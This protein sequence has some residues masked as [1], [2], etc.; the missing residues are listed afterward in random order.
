M[1]ES[2]FKELFAPTVVLVCICL[3][4]SLLLAGTYL[5][6]KP[7][8]EIITKKNAD[9]A[10]AALVPSA[11][12]FKDM[13]GA[14]EF[15][16][17]VDEVFATEDNSAYVITSHSKGFGGTVTV[18]TALDS[19]GKVI[20]VKVTDAS[21]ETPGLGSKATLSSHTDKFKGSAKITDAEGGDGTYIQAVT[22]ASYTS[23]AVYRSV[24]AALQQFKLLGGEK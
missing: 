1:K 4:A 17:G 19:E 12:G 22:G 18:M 24:D 6:T 14:V 15:A 5:V 11:T 7:Q 2:K 13:A 23:R 9:D 20:N 16:E 8:I 21:N 10:R 3:V